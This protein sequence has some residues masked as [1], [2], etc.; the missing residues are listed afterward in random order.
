MSLGPGRQRS[1]VHLGAE[2]TRKEST[3]IDERCKELEELTPYE[4]SEM[5]L[6]GMG[7]R[8]QVLDAVRMTRHNQQR[9]EEDKAAGADEA[10]LGESVS[11]ERRLR[12][13]RL[14]MLIQQF[15]YASRTPA[16]L[17]D[18]K[19]KDVNE[20]MAETSSA[21]VFHTSLPVA[22]ALSKAWFQL[23]LMLM[24]GDRKSVV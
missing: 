8:G 11:A 9:S 10:V 4:W 19:T 7:L 13:S 15:R 2:R 14:A 1:S 22:A 17:L 23:F 3:Q 16:K 24:A 21:S 6:H 20:A 18:M 5:L 12:A